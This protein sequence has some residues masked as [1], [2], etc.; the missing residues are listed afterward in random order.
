MS[1]KLKVYQAIL[2]LHSIYTT[3][4]TGIAWFSGTVFQIYIIIWLHKK[5]NFHEQTGSELSLSIEP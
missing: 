2:I 1:I 5:N 4:H 3:K